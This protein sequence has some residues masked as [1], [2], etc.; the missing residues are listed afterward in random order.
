MY[1]IFARPARPFRRYLEVR[2]S[3]NQRVKPAA[4]WLPLREAVFIFGVAADDMTTDVDDKPFDTS[5]DAETREID[6]TPSLIRRLTQMLEEKSGA[7]RAEIDSSASIFSFFFDDNGSMSISGPPWTILSGGTAHTPQVPT[8]TAPNA[9]GFVR[10]DDEQA[11]HQSSRYQAVREATGLV[12][13][14][15]MVRDFDRAVSSGVVVLYARP[16]SVLADF[17]QL[18]ADAWPLLEVADWQNGVAVAPD[19]STYWSIHVQHSTG[20][21]KSSGEKRGRKKKM[22][23]DGAVKQKVFELLDHHGWPDPSDPEWRSQADVE[24]E[25]SAICGEEVSESTVRRYT[26]RFMAEWRSA[27]DGN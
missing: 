6:A 13:R 24:A 19:G 14:Q 18:P 4:D 15:F 3:R 17:E 20:D 5:T 1:E 7:T 2:L 16:Q 22:D 9:E 21:L 12:W 25:V 10:I 26:A 8:R 23:W 27:K 11:A